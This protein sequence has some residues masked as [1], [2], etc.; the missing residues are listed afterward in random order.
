MLRPSIRGD[1]S[2]GSFT[3]IEL[4]SSIEKGSYRQFKFLVVWIREGLVKGHRLVY[5]GTQSFF[6]CFKQ[7]F[8]FVFMAKDLLVVIIPNGD[9]GVVPVLNCG[10][11]IEE[12]CVCISIGGP[13]DGPL[14]SSRFF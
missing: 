3:T 14:V 7:Q 9:N 13:F 4:I 8:R 6:I 2:G 1:L 5:K 11:G 12:F 10:V